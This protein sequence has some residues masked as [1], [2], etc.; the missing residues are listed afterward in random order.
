[1]FKKIKNGILILK[2]AQFVYLLL[3]IYIT[4]KIYYLIGF[5]GYFIRSLIC[6]LSIL[7]V[8]EIILSIDINQYNN[9][10]YKKNN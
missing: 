9:D 1:M 10:G 2:M 5:I 7:Y 3:W 4:I 6:A 8:Q